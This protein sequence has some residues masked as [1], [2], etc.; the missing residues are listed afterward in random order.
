MFSCGVVLMQDDIHE[1]IVIFIDQHVQ[2]L[3]TLSVRLF[4]Y[5]TWDFLEGCHI[6]CGKCKEDFKNY[7]GS[8]LYKVSF[9]NSFPIYG[10]EI[11]SP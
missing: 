7:H 10:N 2:F 5:V 6:F 9:W 3:N 8:Q 4:R 1:P 11:I